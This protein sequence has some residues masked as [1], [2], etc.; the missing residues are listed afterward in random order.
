MISFNY[1]TVVIGAGAG[2]LVVAIGMAKAGKRVLLIEKG[3]YGGDCT[4]FGCIPSKALIASAK[5]AHNLHHV[6]DLGIQAE[7]QHVDPNNAL[8]RVRTIVAGVRHHEDP[9]ALRKMGVD[10]L[11]GTAKFLDPHIL[12]VSKLDGSKE[13]VRGAQIVIATG[14]HP[15]IPSIPG[16]GQVSYLTNESIFDLQ[17]LP[18]HLAVV[19]GG[20]IGCELAQAFRR[21]GSEVSLIEHASHLLPRSEPEAHQVIREVF[22][23]EGIQLKLNSLL[24]E[25]REHNGEILLRIEDRTGGSEGE[26]TCSHLLIAVG[27][28]PNTSSLALETVGI[29]T[30]QTGAI[31]VDKYGRTSQRHIWAI[32]DVNGGPQFTHM[33]E[34]EGRA[35]LTSLLL[36][37]FLKKKLYGG[38]NIPH[39]TFTDPEVAGIGLTEQQAVREY[40]SRKLA[41]YH[42]SFENL[43]RAITTGR[44]EGFVKV[45][46]KKWSSKILGATLV[47]PGA[48]ELLG[49]LGLAMEH[50]IPLRKIANIIHPYPTYSLALRKAADKWL[51]ETLLPSIKQLLGR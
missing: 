7:I 26:T 10:T 12:E 49:E 33:A 39:C 20:P 11:D 8:E 37:G 25:V 19:G 51:G 18:E 23:R 3:P 4:N 17:E 1:P 31:V 42:F 34:N 35:V 46:T 41:I 6:A 28:R 15:A 48:G 43:D 9:A 2:G 50:G 32:G 40:G 27:R 36:P 47:G 22:H 5:A 24:N 21:L 30:D 45:I 16:L 44:T 14:S 13:R 29:E 38:S